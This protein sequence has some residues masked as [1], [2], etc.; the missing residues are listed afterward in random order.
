MCSG[1]SRIKNLILRVAPVVA[2]LAAIPGVSFAQSDVCI[3]GLGGLASAPTIDGVVDGDPGWNQAVRLNL[4]ELSGTPREGSMQLGTAGG[5]LYL[6]FEVEGTPSPGIDDL[7]VLGFST[8]SSAIQDWRVHVSP[9]TVAGITNTVYQNQDPKERLYWRNSGNWNFNSSA[10]GTADVPS[11]PFIGEIKVSR[12]GNNWAMEMKI[13]ISSN[14]ADAA[15]STLLY[16]PS[17]PTTF[18]LYVNVLSTFDLGSTF[19]QDAWPQT[20]AMLTAGA[21]GSGGN[22]AANRTPAPGTWAVASTFS[23]TACTGVYMTWDN[24][25]GVRHT[26]TGSIGYT[27]TTG[28]G[29]FRAGGLSTGAI[30]STVDDCIA[31]LPNDNTPWPTGT[32]LPDNYFVAKPGNDGPPA[33]RVYVKFYVAPWGIPGAFD[34]GAPNAYW[35]P[36]GELFQPTGAPTVHSTPEATV[37]TDVGGMPSLAAP[38][39]T[40]SWQLSYKQACVYTES[41][42]YTNQGHHCIQAEAH[43]NDPSVVIR[44]KSIQFNH[45]FLTSSVAQSDAT[46]SVKGRGRPAQP[47]RPHELLLFTQKLIQRFTRD[48]QRFYPSAIKGDQAAATRIAAA[49]AVPRQ[50][51]AFGPVPA[52]RYPNGLDE[53]MT[54]ITNGYLKQGDFM[55]IGSKKYQYAQ[56]VG[57]YSYFA[58]HAGV[59]QNWVESLALQPSTKTT[60]GKGASL[61]AFDARAM[62]ADKSARPVNAHLLQLAENDTVALAITAEAQDGGPTTGGPTTDDGCGKLRLGSGGAALAAFVVTGFAWKRRRKSGQK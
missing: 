49:T 4:K 2:L 35:H 3:P 54:V 20:V 37:P 36:L 27:S 46:I 23:R 16:L 25:L 50:F 56:Y 18:K 42:Y 39:S 60:L 62:A 32:V 21:T 30:L 34:P 43:S 8:T 41:F 52:D 15:G 57:G 44:T 38:L 19:T 48:G 17:S 53:G 33:N 40:P 45:N 51:R 55:I 22:S 6:S 7:V 26:P 12:N 59:V 11:Q 13:P 58:G 61:Q 10:G 14:P 29:P 5:F 31:N 9:F 1:I 47:G 24:N 28:P